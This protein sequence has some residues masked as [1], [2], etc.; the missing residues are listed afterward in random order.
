MRGEGWEHSDEGV[1]H[2]KKRSVAGFLSIE[3]T[4]EVKTMVAN[5]ENIAGSD[6]MSSARPGLETQMRHAR[7]IFAGVK[8]GPKLLTIT[9]LGKV[10]GTSGTLT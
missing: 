6:C 9:G 7:D 2:A 1:T 4:V 8:I 3:G 5:M 10:M